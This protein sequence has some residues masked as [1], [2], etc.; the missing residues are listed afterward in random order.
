[1]VFEKRDDEMSDE[2]KPCPFCGEEAE[3]RYQSN[4]YGVRCKKC[5]ATVAAFD[6][7]AEAIEAWN[8][9]VATDKNVGDKER[10]KGEWKKIG[11]W[12]RHYRCD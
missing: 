1:M 3:V 10:T 4:L 9:R 2:L 7:E 5:L 12:G 11:H 6:T 8:Q